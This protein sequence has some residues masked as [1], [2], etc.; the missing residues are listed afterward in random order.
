MLTEP[1]EM[2]T[3]YIYTRVSTEEQARHGYSIE[4]Q[5]RAC[6]E[7]AQKLG[8]SVLDVFVDEGETATAADRPGFQN[9]LNYCEDK[10]VEAIVVWQT[11]RFARN[12]VDHF[13]IK[14]KL[15]KLGIKLLS[16]A[17]PM[18]D[19][20]PEGRAMDGMMA[21]WNAYFSRDLS[22]KTKKG[23]VQK[24]EEGWWPGWAP[25][26]YENVKDERGKGAV[27]VDPIKG[28]VV[29]E[30]LEK[31]SSGNMNIEDLQNWFFRRGLTSKTNKVLQ[32]SVVHGVLKNPFYYGLMKWNG[33]E[34]IGNHEPLI[35]KAT[36][37][38][39]QYILA[40]HRGF[41]IRQ[42]KHD[43]LLRSFI[44]CADCGQRYTAEYHYSPKKLAKRG[45]KIAYYHCAKRGGCKSPYVKQE[46]L[47]T[48]VENQFKH[49]E[50]APAFIEMVTKKAKEAFSAQ[51]GTI[52][53]EKRA[54]LN[55]KMALEAKRT[56][57]EDRLLDNTIDRNT[58]KR[59][60]MEL[61]AQINALDTQVAELDQKRQFDV[62]FL[63]EVLSFTRNIYRT[64]KEA[65]P[66]LKRHY[67]RFFFERFLVKDKKIVKVA[68]S[69]LFATLQK[70]QMV[71]LRSN[72]LPGKDS[73][74]RPSG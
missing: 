7:Y 60:H 62:N 49:L 36:Y 47:E 74:L 2:K 31:F 26:G 67:L 35:S 8:L 54:I 61:Q 43:F 23:L 52:E 38:L 64:Y 10:P 51:R 37:D 19:D 14:D 32:Y 12:E 24:W 1:I 16:V 3:C 21:V 25:L 57:L 48:L 68:I 71:I 63:E 44:T 33:L 22:R 4:A 34:K 73:N 18:L 56:T 5:K 69:P 28:L 72:L 27:Q 66:F 30:G 41:L 50:F 46:D 65:P 42:R 17:Q 11:D 29:K 58:F 13:L 15:Q 55:Q 53:N 6:M 20:S 70:E 9:M 45:G 39:N 40:K 59:K